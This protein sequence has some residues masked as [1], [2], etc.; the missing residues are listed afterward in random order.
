MK[1]L[2]KDEN[3]LLRSKTRRQT[4]DIRNSCKSTFGGIIENEKGQLK[5]VNYKIL[6]EFCLVIEQDLEKKKWK[7]SRSEDG[8]VIGCEKYLNIGTYQTVK[9]VDEVPS[10]IS[11][12]A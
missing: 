1:S 6:T 3:L 5:C 8:K 7:L 2:I 4:N 12:H 11:C 9:D 10:W